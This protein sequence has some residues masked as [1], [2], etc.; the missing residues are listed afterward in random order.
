M[1][2]R[3]LGPLEALDGD[4]PVALGGSKLRAVLALLLLHPNETVSSDRT[5][6]KCERR[7]TEGCC[8]GIG[9]PMTASCCEG[10]PPWRALR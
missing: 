10:R 8:A 2:F 6:L 1:D 7:T 5:S 4:L 3:I 9:C